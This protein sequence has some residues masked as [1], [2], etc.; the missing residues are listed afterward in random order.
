MTEADGGVVIL[1][2][3]DAATRRSLENLVLRSGSA[4]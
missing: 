1:V 4:P 3:D 2:D